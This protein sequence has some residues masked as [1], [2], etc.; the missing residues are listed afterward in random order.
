[1]RADPP[2]GRSPAEPTFPGAE[3][4]RA[5]SATL[6]GEAAALRLASVKM[7]HRGHDELELARA[8]LAAGYRA[9]DQACQTMRAA[10]PG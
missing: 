3:R 9:L 5:E 8:N 4:A 7:R 1:M 10:D 6:R 2:A